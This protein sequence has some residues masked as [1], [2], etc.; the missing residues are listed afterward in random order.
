MNKINVNLNNKTIK[1][2]WD[3]IFS[4]SEDGKYSIITILNIIG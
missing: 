4:I 2:I 3:F 1:N